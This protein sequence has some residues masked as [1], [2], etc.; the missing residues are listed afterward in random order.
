[1]ES[2]TLKLPAICAGILLALA[3]PC[4]LVSSASDSVKPVDYILEDSVWR[5]NDDNAWP[6]ADWHTPS[7]DDSG[8]LSGEAYLATEDETGGVGVSTVLRRYKDV[9]FPTYYFRRSFNVRDP[10]RVVN[11]SFNIDY[12][13]AYAVYLNSRMVA[14]SNWDCEWSNHEDGSC[15]PYPHNSLIDNAKTVGDPQFPR[16]DLTDAQLDYL[17]DGENYIAVAVKQGRPDSTDAAFMLTLY[18]FEL[19]AAE[20]LI[21][22]DIVDLAVD[23]MIVAAVITIPFAFYRKKLS[24]RRK[25]KSLGKM[26]REKRKIQEMIKVAKTKYHRRELDGESFREII[27]ENQG[28]LIQL[29]A[30][31]REMEA[32]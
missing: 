31:I 17:V 32:E 21:P 1:M 7:Y 24:K 16:V 26:R 25:E 9:A 19:E 29:E 5:Y 8:W 18:G 10:S 4:G 3:F 13:D 30:E 2:R 23:V 12:D 22:W 15:T 27:R 28:K 6:G 20:P 14:S 11:M